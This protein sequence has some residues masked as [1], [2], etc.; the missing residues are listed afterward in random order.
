MAGLFLLLSMV[1]CSG[2]GTVEC[3]D[4][5]GSSS[6][7]E[8]CH[9]CEGSGSANRICSHC[10]G[11]NAA[12]DQCIFCE[13]SGTERHTCSRCKGAGVQKAQCGRCGGAGR[14]VDCPKYRSVDTYN[15][16]GFPNRFEYRTG[17][18]ARFVD[19]GNRIVVR[20][21]DSRRIL[22]R[23]PKPLPLDPGNHN[24]ELH[25]LDVDGDGIA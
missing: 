10:R 7:V 18:F 23:V 6:Q 14:I 15:S 12:R 3:P 22:L 4:C 8:T 20:E 1:L 19:E 24:P 5:R 13:G 9:S 17:V 16:P 21:E 2:S 25:Y 11:K